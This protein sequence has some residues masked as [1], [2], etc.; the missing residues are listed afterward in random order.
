MDRKIVTV[1]LCGPGRHEINDENGEP[2]TQFIF[3]GNVKKPLDFLVAN[4]EVEKMSIG[5]F[6]DS[7]MAGGEAWLTMHRRKFN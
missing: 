2:I 4:G 6:F 1:G 3:E 7:C 5:E